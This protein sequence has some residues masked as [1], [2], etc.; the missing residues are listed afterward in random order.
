M[1]LRKRAI[2]KAL[3]WRVIA[4]TVT[5]SLAYAMTGHLEF[6]ATLGVMDTGIKLIAYY[7]HE[8]VWANVAFGRIKPPTYDI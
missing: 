3:T 5:T 6:A 2:A 1:E 7:G 4:V 8:R